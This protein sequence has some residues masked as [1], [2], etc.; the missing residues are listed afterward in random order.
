LREIHEVGGHRTFAKQLLN[1]ELS[2]DDLRAI[3]DA[4]KNIKG[5]GARYPEELEERTGR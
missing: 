5:V 4:L 2:N 1:L 3:E